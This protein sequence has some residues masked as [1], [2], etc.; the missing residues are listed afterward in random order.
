MHEIDFRFKPDRNDQ[1]RRA[2]KQRKHKKRIDKGV[3]SFMASLNFDR[4][5]IC[6]SEE[7]GVESGKYTNVTQPKEYV[8]SAKILEMYKNLKLGSLWTQFSSLFP[9]ATR[10]VASGARLKVPYGMDKALYGVPVDSLHP[11]KAIYRAL[12]VPERFLIESYKPRDWDT[13]FPN[14]PVGGPSRD[15]PDKRFSGHEPYAPW[16]V[17]TTPLTGILWDLLNEPKLEKEARFAYNPHIYLEG[18]GP[19][20]RRNDLLDTEFMHRYK[21]FFEHNKE[22]KLII[23]KEDNDRIIEAFEETV[24]FVYC[25][26]IDCQGNDGGLITKSVKRVK[27]L[28]KLEVPEKPTFTLD[29]KPVIFTNINSREKDPLVTGALMARLFVDDKGIKFLEGKSING[30]DKFVTYL[31]GKVRE[32]LEKT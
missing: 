18:S 23:K 22:I 24:D 6:C 31:E 15:N 29:F 11:K 13:P 28:K 14:M 7:R 5:G 25:Q 19:I 3:K 16:L 26:G 9:R 21:T 10:Y 1:N 30:V 12:F 8:L 4:Q 17:D 32:N 20:L 27:G 2:N